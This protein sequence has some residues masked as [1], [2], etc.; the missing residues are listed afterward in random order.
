MKTHLLSA[1]LCSILASGGFAVAP[2]IGDVP[3]QVIAHSTNT[4][5]LYFTIGDTETAFTALAMTASSSNTT[6]VPNVAANLTLGGTASQRTLK[7][8][9]AAGQTGTATITLTV[10]DGQALTASSTFNITVTTANT[11]PTLT[12][13]TGYQIVSPGQTPAALGF[14]IGD[15]QTAATALSVVATS[16]NTALVPNGNISLG[17]SGASRT[18]QVTPAAGQRGTAVIKL[19]VTDPLGASAQSEFIFS[20]FEPASANNAIRQP[21]G[22]Y[23]L[24]SAVGT[25][26]NGVSM[27]DA[28]VRNKPFVDG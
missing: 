11:A 26:I 2:I 20:V 13:P 16:S 18:V 3:D 8:T 17:G 9:P 1:A 27:R 10:T 4:G 12:G 23:V 19:K 21:R 24:D 25:Q 7:V 5:T 22:L 6:L 28:N 14:T 15:A